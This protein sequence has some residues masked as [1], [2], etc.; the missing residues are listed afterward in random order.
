MGGTL[1]RMTPYA[2]SAL[3]GLRDRLPR[4]EEYAAWARA[5]AAE[6]VAAGFRVTPEPPHTNT[7]LAFVDGSADALNERL[8][9]VMERERVAPGRPWWD[10]DT[11]GVAVTEM[12][13]PEA[14][15]DFEPAQ[16]ATWWRE[17]AGL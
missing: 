7:F 2:V 8:A 15:L 5:F 6:L 16:V 13:V 1:Y 17:I 14:A 10:G 12:A 3:V 9:E 11:P 4:M